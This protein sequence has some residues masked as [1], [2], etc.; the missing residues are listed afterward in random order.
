MLWRGPQWLDLMF[1]IP[2][3]GSIMDI[4]LMAALDRAALFP[5]AINQLLWAAVL[6]LTALA[7]WFSQRDINREKAGLLIAASLL[8]APYAASTL[9][10]VAVGVIP[11][12]QKRRWLG[13]VLIALNWLLLLFNQPAYRQVLGYY[14]TGVLLLTWAALLWSVWQAEIRPHRTVR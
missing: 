8:L 13:L 6:A 9:S 5:A 1:R 4:S 3:Q 11:L 14:S 12:F 10:L 2:Q 7:V